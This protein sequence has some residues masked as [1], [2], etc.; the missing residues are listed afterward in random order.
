ML[1]GDGER[2]VAHDSHPTGA[3]WTGTMTTRETPMQHMRTDGATFT[4]TYNTIIHKSV[5]D[6]THNVTT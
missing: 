2:E 5:S 6:L 1:A 4:A 3:S